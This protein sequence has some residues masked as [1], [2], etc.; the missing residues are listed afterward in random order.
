MIQSF[1]FFSVYYLWLLLVNSCQP[2]ASLRFYR[3]E[4][5]IL[6]HWDGSIYSI[7]KRNDTT[8][9]LI[10]DWLRLV[11]FIWSDDSTHDLEDSEPSSTWSD[12]IHLGLSLRRIK[13]LYHIFHTAEAV[14]MWAVNINIIFFLTELMDRRT[15]MVIT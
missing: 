6:L 11:C 13:S 8:W 14:D 15:S 7:N 12:N 9:S 1:I 2:Q 4:W 10:S 5:R 3:A